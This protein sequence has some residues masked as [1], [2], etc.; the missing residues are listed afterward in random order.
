MK[1]ITR[2]S[3]SE[4]NERLSDKFKH[5]GNGAYADVYQ[6]P[7]KDVVVKV[8]DTKDDEGYSKY[9]K[10]ALKHQ[11]NPYVPKIHHVEKFKNKDCGEE[12][13]IVFM[14]KLQEARHR[15]FKDLMEKHMSKSDYYGGS[16]DD[17]EEWEEIAATTKDKHMKALAKFFSKKHV[18]V[19]LDLHSENYM[20]RGKQLVFTDPLA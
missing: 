10:W 2:E 12:I 14:E 8:F 5:L 16:L 6:H 11:D 17:W 15:D 1:R 20:W 13:T 3:I 4:Y 19:D 9:L 18:N 7:N